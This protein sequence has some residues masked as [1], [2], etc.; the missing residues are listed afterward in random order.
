[1]P[2]PLANTSRILRLI[3]GAAFMP[4]Y[5][6]RKDLAPRDIVARAIDAELKRTGDDHVALDMTHLPADLLVERF[7]NIHGACRLASN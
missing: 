3:D 4:H 2:L 5:H 7:P 6:E 1:M